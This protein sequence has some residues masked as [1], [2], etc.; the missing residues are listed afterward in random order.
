MKNHCFC[1]IDQNAPQEFVV[2][3]LGSVGD[4]GAVCGP[5]IVN[6]NVKDYVFGCSCVVQGYGRFPMYVKGYCEFSFCYSA[7]DVGSTCSGDRMAKIICYRMGFC[8]K[9]LRGH[10]RTPWVVRIF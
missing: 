2:F 8:S 7:P 3:L 1:Y 6:V 4:A 10:W 5:F 9:L